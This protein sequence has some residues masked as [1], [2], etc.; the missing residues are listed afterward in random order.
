MLISNVEKIVT[1]VVFCTFNTSGKLSLKKSN[2]VPK[3]E[4]M[5]KYLLSCRIQF[6]LC[7]QYGEQEQV[8]GQLVF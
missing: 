8:K 4:I 3:G 1:L 6:F 5:S 7:G 2:L